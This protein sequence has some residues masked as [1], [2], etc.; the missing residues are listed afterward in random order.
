MN[1]Y[2]KP[3]TLYKGTNYNPDGSPV[4]FSYVTAF[5]SE[6]EDINGWGGEYLI[7]AAD[8]GELIQVGLVGNAA[9]YDTASEFENYAAMMLAEK[10]V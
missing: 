4:D 6:D 8:T 2:D 5:L 9:G 3:V 7:A 10:G 1:I